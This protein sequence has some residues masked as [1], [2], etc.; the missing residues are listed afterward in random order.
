MNN[1]TGGIH[2]SFWW[3][4][5]EDTVQ[6]AAYFAC[7]ISRWER[8]ITSKPRRKVYK[9]V[10]FYLTNSGG[11]GTWGRL[12]QCVKA[13][14]L[15]SSCMTDFPC[16]LWAVPGGLN[17]NRALSSLWAPDLQTAYIVRRCRVWT[18]V[19]AEYSEELHSNCLVWAL[20]EHTKMYLVCINLAQF[21]IGR[22]PHS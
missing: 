5:R 21:E 16:D 11:R 12:L 9:H 18:C 13:L 2:T 19:P 10:R 4:P 14:G 22:F 17:F 7:Q 1:Q 20:L 6:L 3:L 8:K 15:I